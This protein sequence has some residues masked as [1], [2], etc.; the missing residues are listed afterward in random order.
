MAEPQ[1]VA[2][3]L[4]ANPL[5]DD[6]PESAPVLNDL[7]RGYVG[8]G[9]EGRKDSVGTL[10]GDTKVGTKHGKGLTEGDHEMDEL[11]KNNLAIVMPSLALV[12]FLAALDQTIVATALPTIS[13]DLNATPAEY[14]W[15]GTAYTLAMTLLAPVNG[16]VSD[17]VGRKPMLYVSIVVFFVFSAL[18]GAAKSM[19]WLIVARAFQGLGGGSI[20]GLT[21]IVVSD[22]V[23]LNRRG[24]YQ[25]YMGG[26]WG[27]AAVLWLI[28]RQ[29]FMAMVFLHQPP[30][31][32]NRPGYLDLYLESQPHEEVLVQTP[33]FLVMVSAALLIVG[34]SSA[35]DDGFDKPEAIALIVVGGVTFGG[36]VV[37]FLYTKRMAI[38]P[39]RMFKN[40]TTLAFLIGSTLHATAFIPVN[41][42]LPQMFQGVR[43]SD[44]LHSGIQL[45]PFACCVAWM[46][47]VAG[48]INSRLRIIRPVVWVGYIF[49]A[50]GYG[51]FYRYYTSTVSY[52]MQEGLMVIPG[53][54]IGLSLQVTMLILQAAMP[55]KEMAAVTSAWSM[56]RS[57]G[58]SVGLA[59]FTAI[60]NT[61]L[62]AKL[63]RIPGFGTVFQVPTSAAGYAALHNLPDGETKS[64][65]LAAFADSFRICWIVA[66]GMFIV[67]LLV[68]LNTRSYSLDRA[69]GSAA[70]QRL[71]EAI[72]S[73]DQKT[74]EKVDDGTEKA[75]AI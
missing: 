14:S 5:P 1:E 50:L 7:E 35:A 69:R 41:Y 48:Q 54:G 12:L 26:A 39:A 73:D 22:I 53:V 63:Q 30:H 6:L 72:P 45:L 64:A 43:G 62:R 3:A 23:P 56:T 44:A 34:F 52:A 57:L 40:R 55:L 4:G 71:G 32:W 46:T 17:I 49:A 66:C 18:C 21:S 9:S 19:T 61:G 67:A 31:L 15:V 2:L 20:I 25:G 59:I 10:V 65:V 68:T 8:P 70:K 24:V 60:L 11:P 74:S 28:D 38:I 16:R 47:V 13:G 58:G 37:N 75:P 36:A 27:V 42:L 51:L 33:A 29:S